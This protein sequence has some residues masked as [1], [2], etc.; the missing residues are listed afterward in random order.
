MVTFFFASSGLG[1][2]SVPVEVFRWSDGVLH[3]EHFRVLPGDAI[4]GEKGGVD[5]STGFTLVDLRPDFRNELHRPR[6]C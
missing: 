2:S 1:S 3:E 5:Y 4:G 6:G